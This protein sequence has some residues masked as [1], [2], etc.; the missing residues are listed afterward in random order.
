MKH[1]LVMCAEFEKDRWV[2][3]DKVSR[4]VG[5]ESGWMN[6]KSYLQ[7]GLGKGV[8]GVSGTVMEEIGKCVMYG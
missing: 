5:L 2:L 6:T 3:A 4:I 8:R 1:L 7:G